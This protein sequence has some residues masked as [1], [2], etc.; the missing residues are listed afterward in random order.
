MLLSD[1]GATRG[2]LQTGKIAARYAAGFQRLAENAR[3]RTYVFAV[4]DDANIPLL[5]VLAR[6]DGVLEWVRSTEPIE[7]KLNAFLSKIGR[8]P[9]QQ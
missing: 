1:G 6:D 7:F 4:G 9:I 2:S 8:R 3:P 5:R